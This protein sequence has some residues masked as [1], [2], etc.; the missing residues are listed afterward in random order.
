ME[1]FTTITNV[2]KVF[3][4]S[5]I[6]FIAAILWTPLLTRILYKYQLWR[7]DVRQTSPDGSKTPLFA[8]LH[9]DRETRVPRLG[10]VLIWVTTLG[11]A[12]LFWLLGQ[13]TDI[14]LFDK[15]NFIS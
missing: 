11:I 14:P 1:N 10:G 12:V 15:L 2:I 3:G 8:A 6:S 5:A 13:F 7:K 9:K 4:L